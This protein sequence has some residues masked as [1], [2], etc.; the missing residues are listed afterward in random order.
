MTWWALIRFLHVTSAALWV[1][2]Q[3]TISLVVLPLARDTL[4]TGQRGRVLRAIGRRF[5]QFT[6]AFFLPV[7]ITTGIA[8]A[9]HKGVTWESLYY[10]G[11]GRV[12][13]AKLLL[14]VAVMVAAMLHGWANGRGRPAFARAMAVTSLVGSLG[15]V[16]LATALPAT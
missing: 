6:G 4:D 12:L 9:W 15:V 7:Q 10:P 5:G 3:L 11:Y 14:F 8:M 13:A 16:L 2:G 1:G